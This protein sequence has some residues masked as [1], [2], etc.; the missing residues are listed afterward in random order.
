MYIRPLSTWDISA[1]TGRVFMKFD[2]WV[3]FR[4]YV[5][6]IQ[7]SLKPDENNGYFTWRPVYIYD[8]ISLDSS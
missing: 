6:N 5:E 8:N 2:I 4:K 3:F 7:V 1:S